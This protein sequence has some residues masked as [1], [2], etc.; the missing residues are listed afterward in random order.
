MRRSGC[1]AVCAL[2]QLG[3]AARLRFPFAGFAG[4]NHGAVVRQALGGGG[5]GS[6]GRILLGLD[7]GQCRCHRIFP[8]C[9]RHGLTALGGGFGVARFTGRFL[10]LET[11]LLG[12]ETL[13]GAFGFFGLGAGFANVVFGDLVVLHQRD[14][15]RADPGAGAALD[16]VHQVELLGLVIL[17]GPAVPVELLRQQGGRAGIG[18][19]AATDARLLRAGGGQFG[20]RRRQQAV[21]GLDHR[22][23]GVGQGKAHHGTTH[24]HPLLRFRLQLETLQQP[25][26]RRT[27]AH[28]GVAG[29]FEAVAGE[30]DDPLD[31][32]LAV[33]NG[34]LDGK[35]GGHVKHHDADIDR[36]AAFGHLTAGQQLDGL[37]G[38]ARGVLGRH[39][40]DQHIFIGGMAGQLLDRLGLVVFHPDQGQLGLEQVLEHPDA[41]H[42]LVGILLHQPIIGSDIGFALQ[43]VDDQDLG[44]LAAAVELAVGREH[45]AAKARHP[46]LLN[47][48]EQLAPLQIPVIGFAIALDPLILTIGGEDDTEI[49]EPG[50]V[51]NRV[52]ANL[53]DGARGRGM[54]RDDPPLGITGQRLP[55]FDLVAHLHQQIAGGACV[56]AQRNNEARRQTGVYHRALA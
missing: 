9:G 22:H 39:R 4:G 23:H 36:A 13:L 49:A 8:A 11:G 28:P 38:T 2:R 51:G 54:D 5:N 18:A 52:V 37:L 27:Q 7:A 42:D 1:F 47:A 20:L 56:L 50:G 44:Q 45:G 16:A 41:I 48:L 14:L 12:L 35:H 29:L 30:G 46:R 10:P 26:Y 25:A 3:G 55:F 32:R 40:L 43:P 34:A 33:D 17:L 31:Q 53:G 19:G 21:G 24:D 6:D 15:A